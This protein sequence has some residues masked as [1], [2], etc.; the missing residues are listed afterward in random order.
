MLMQELA[1]RL[2]EQRIVTAAQAARLLKMPRLEFE[3][4]L[5]QN[6]IPLHGGPEDLRADL[7]NLE[8]A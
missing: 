4:L 2:F 3:R 7:R 8:E 1:L 6:E 5:A